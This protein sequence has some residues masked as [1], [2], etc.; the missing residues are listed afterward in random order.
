MCI[1]TDK[2]HLE[3]SKLSITIPIIDKL[4]KTIIECKVTRSK[5]FIS[6]YLTGTIKYKVG[7]KYN[8]PNTEYINNLYELV[9]LSQN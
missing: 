2:G 4:P 9:K 8:T 6:D 3:K 5:S 7:L 1:E